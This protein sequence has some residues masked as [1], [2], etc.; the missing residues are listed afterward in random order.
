MAAVV[1]A[2]II[3]TLLAIIT[4]M[5]CLKERRLDGNRSQFSRRTAAEDHNYSE[6]AAYKSVKRELGPD[7]DSCTTAKGGKYHDDPLEL[8]YMEAN[9]ACTSTTKLDSIEIN[10]NVAYDAFA[11]ILRHTND[12][13]NNGH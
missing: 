8:T 1:T 13:F 10:Q 11:R 7:S 3:I 2:I 5:C 12:Q 4:V 6:C 9:D